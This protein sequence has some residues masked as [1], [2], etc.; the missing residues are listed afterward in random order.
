MTQSLLLAAAEVNPLQSLMFL[1]V[2]LGVHLQAAFPPPTDSI[3][4]AV[5]AAAGAA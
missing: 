4:A 2:A 5:L 1:V 3:E